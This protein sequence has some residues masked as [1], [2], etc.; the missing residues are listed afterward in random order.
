MIS[1]QP[2]TILFITFDYGLVLF[3]DVYYLVEYNKYNE[4][5]C[6][7]ECDYLAGIDSFLN[8][9]K[10]AVHEQFYFLNNFVQT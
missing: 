5:T 4:T 7:R 10:I 8:H 9:Q 2:K 3:L 1:I 6:W